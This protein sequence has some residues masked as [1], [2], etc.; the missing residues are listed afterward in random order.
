[1]R[2]LN[3]REKVITDN[4]LSHQLSQNHYQI[5]G[6]TKVHVQYKHVHACGVTHTQLLSI[7]YIY[8]TFG[9]IKIALMMQFTVTIVLYDV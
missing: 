2:H 5:K 1:M 3:V 4:L 7:K 8:V 6:N 9:M